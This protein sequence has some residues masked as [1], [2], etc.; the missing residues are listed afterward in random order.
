MSS[1]DIPGKVL[2]AWHGLSPTTSLEGITTTFSITSS[3]GERASETRQL[4][5][6]TLLGHGEAQI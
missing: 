1:H 3:R 5:K 4:V 2:N 6:V